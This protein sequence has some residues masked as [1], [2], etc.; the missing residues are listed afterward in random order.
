[1]GS[2]GRLTSPEAVRRAMSEFDHLKGP[3]F[4]DKH[5]VSRS[6][7]YFID[8]GGRYYDAA[9]ITAV[10]YS[11]Q[12]P[13]EGLLRKSELKGAETP[14]MALRRLGFT[15]VPDLY[16][17]LVLATNERHARAEFAKWQDK[18]GE[19]YHFPNGYHNKIIPGREFIYYRGSRRSS[20]ARATPDYFGWG[21]I[22]DVY[23]DPATKEEKPAKRHWKCGIKEYRVFASPVPFKDPDGRYLELDGIAPPKRY[24]DT[25]VRLISQRS[26]RR[27]LAAAGI[28]SNAA[29]QSAPP[30]TEQH[31]K[32]LE[33]P[34]QLLIPTKRSNQTADGTGTG[35]MRPDRRNARAKVIGDRGEELILK[36][37]REQI[38][39]EKDR[40]KIIWVADDG[41]TP[42]WDIED[43]RNE[44]Q[45][46][47]YEIKSTCGQSFSAIDIT[48][49][50]WEAAKKL[51]AR[52]NLVLV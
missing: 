27:I 44:H 23:L 45:L 32:V 48:A 31:V 13:N 12:H 35:I 50:E 6:R 16:R 8:Y 40:H 21:R 46:V 2:L 43:R 41:E 24:W 17:Y 15:V 29:P 33:G 52:Y 19:E 25:G 11:F 20:G 4:F 47:A 5:K 34:L 36:L 14:E 38:S 1:M 49:N 9:A 51:R 28:V 39:A 30:I 26:F 3:A 7:D 10:A 18:T 42:G 37:L 22:G